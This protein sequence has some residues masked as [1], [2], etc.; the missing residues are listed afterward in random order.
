MKVLWIASLLAAPWQGTPPL[1]ASRRLRGCTFGA[2]FYPNAIPTSLTIRHVKPTAQ[3]ICTESR[4]IL[5]RLVITASPPGGDERPAE[6]RVCPA[7]SRSLRTLPGQ[8]GR[9]TERRAAGAVLTAWGVPEPLE[10]LELS[11]CRAVEAFCCISPPNHLPISSRQTGGVS[12]FPLAEL[13]RAGGEHAAHRSPTVGA[14]GNMCWDRPEAPHSCEP[15]GS[16]QSSAAEPTSVTTEPCG[17]PDPARGQEL[18]N[19]TASS[20]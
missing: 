2:V 12:R 1:Q 4:K 6:Q 5:R 14:S 17:Q 9:Q 7:A 8:T 11:Y 15:P 3:S 18:F 19:N 16:E 13:M 10:G 20:C